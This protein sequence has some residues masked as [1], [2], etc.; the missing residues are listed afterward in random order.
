MDQQPNTSSQTVSLAEQL[1]QAYLCGQQQ[2]GKQVLLPLAAQV[3]EQ[4]QKTLAHPPQTAVL[5]EALKPFASQAVGQIDCLVEGVLLADTAR[6]LLGSQPA[7]VMQSQEAS[8]PKQQAS[9]QALALYLLFQS[10]T[11][12]GPKW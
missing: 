5:L 2:F 8:A 3:Q 7:L 9:M 6:R 4:K 10:R 11:T 1:Q 12:A